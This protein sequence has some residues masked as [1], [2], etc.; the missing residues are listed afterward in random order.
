[1]GK[2]DD[3]RNIVKNKSNGSQSNLSDTSVETLK[4]K[5]GGRSAKSFGLNVGAGVAVAASVVIAG[6]AIKAASNYYDRFEIA[7]EKAKKTAEALSATYNEVQEA[8]NNFRTNL[9][10]YENGVKNLESLTKGT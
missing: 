6:A 8:E 3:G 2:T 9:D 7:A 1:L 10:N 4:K 5:L